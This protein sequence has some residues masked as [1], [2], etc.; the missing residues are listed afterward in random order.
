MT[1]TVIEATS[2]IIEFLEIE[3]ET[4]NAA[5]IKH[6]AI[7][8]P[9]L[10]IGYNG[11]EDNNHTHI[12]LELIED[13]EDFKKRLSE[14]LKPYLPDKVIKE[15][16]N[17]ISEK[18]YLDNSEIVAKIV[19]NKNKKQKAATEL[20]A[21][22]AL[23]LA[24]AH[25]KELF[26]DEFGK[27][28][29]AIIV[30]DHTEILSMEEGR[31]KKWLVRLF[32]TK[33]KSKIL[34]DEDL[35]KAI[36]LLEADAE[37]DKNIKRHRLDLRVRGHNIDNNGNNDYD[38]NEETENFVEIY[39]DLT[40]EKWQAAKITPQGWSIVNDPPIL[41]RRHEGVEAQIYPAHSG[42]YPNDILDQL[43]S[44][45][46]IKNNLHK[47]LL[48]V[49]IV[50]L[51]WPNTTPKPVLI[52]SGS[53]GSA[54]STMFDILR[55]FADPNV[56][57]S[58]SL[59]K[60]VF[61][62]KQYLSHN[63]MSFFDNVSYISDEQS[64]CLC[65]AVTGAGD[66][67][68]ELYKNDSDI[69]YN[70]R[71]IIGL[72]GITNAA[73]RPDLLDR[74]LIIELDTIQKL[75]RELLRIIKRN[76]NRIKAQSLAFGFDII[77]DVLRERQKWKGIDDD[78]FGMKDLI[79]KYGGL[80]RMADYAILA[81]Q[82]ASAIARKEGKEYKPGS[83]LKAWDENQDTLNLEALKAS[84]LSEALISFMTDR[85]VYHK[86]EPWEGSPSQLLTTLNN[87]VLEHQDIGIDLKSKS[88][89][90]DP[91]EFGKQLSR[92]KSNLTPLGIIVE[93]W[94]TK[95]NIMYKI[96]K[97]PTPTYTPTPSENS[98]LNEH[99]NGV[100]ALSSTPTPLTPKEDENQARIT[101]DVGMGVGGVCGVDAFDK[102]SRDIL[103]TLDKAIDKAMLDSQG[104]NKGYFTKQ[105][106]VFSLVMLPNEEW[107]VDEAEQT[108][109]AL[110]DEGEIIEKLEGIGEKDCY[111]RRIKT[112]EIAI[113][114]AR[115]AAPDNNNNA[116]NTEK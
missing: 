116:T 57:G 94:R 47:F 52:L 76:Y 93:S 28:H 25:S 85:E 102:K 30:E 54:K 113:C 107:T 53:Q 78:Y 115:S 8:E 12:E 20:P 11:K 87:F 32:F 108:L 65:R 91:T 43:V 71:R 10:L 24:K 21:V 84:P 95:K 92:I 55:D 2:P 75:D 99:V 19:D 110:A 64:D 62:L 112:E 35:K 100:G 86:T 48:K 63:Y 26:V 49:Y 73:S 56:A 83:F 90:H 66:M 51:F 39:Y 27:A 114:A 16:E 97:Q 59:Q 22:K 37:F 79:Q 104:N 4:L 45:F 1:T 67:K 89:P 36:Q 88:W 5:G 13:F 42:N 96:S 38:S 3:D 41:F 70:Y 9:M 61:N 98:S 101:S 46:N 18:I 44:L 58:Y 109:Y 80:P 7:N 60:E 50:S 31:F 17:Y 29:A 40:N 33:N 15:L 23:N 82:V 105:D 14:K 106:F 6:I 81:E 69:I 74:A 111:K 77:S 34:N 72:N 103:H 68:R